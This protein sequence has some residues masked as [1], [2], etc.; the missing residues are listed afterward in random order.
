MK[1]DVKSIII[2]VLLLTS[3]GF[4]LNWYFS[5]DDASKQ[6]VKEL[7]NQLVKLDKDLKESD[8]RLKESEVKSDSLEKVTKKSQLEAAR[9]AELTK[10]AEATVAKYKVELDKAKQNTI[11]VKE[12]IK[13]MENKPANRTEQELIESLKNKTK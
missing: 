9:Q 8:K 3:I 13:E 4:G 1:F 6:R 5:G 2:L 11:I 12:K 7:E 10:K